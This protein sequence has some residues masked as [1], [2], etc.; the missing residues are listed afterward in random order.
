[1]GDP[2]PFA[3]QVSEQNGI[4]YTDNTSGWSGSVTV[5]FKSAR[6]NQLKQVEIDLEF[7]NRILHA[8]IPTEGVLPGEYYLLATVRNAKGVTRSV[9]AKV[10]LAAKATSPAKTENNASD[11]DQIFAFDQK[12]ERDGTLIYN[13]VFWDDFGGRVN[14]KPFRKEVTAGEIVHVSIDASK[15]KG[16]LNYSTSLQFKPKGQDTYDVLNAHSGKRYFE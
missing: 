2:I 12:M 14:P 6:S 5:N 9:Y 11:Q 16:Q 4:A 10:I 1:V 3:V 8:L 13:V 15:V 7:S